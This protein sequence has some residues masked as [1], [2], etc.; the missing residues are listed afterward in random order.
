MK[1][2]PLR[3]HVGQYFDLLD[4]HYIIIPRVLRCGNSFKIDVA[5][6][7]IDSTH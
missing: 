7:E 5:N 3:F 1:C 6:Q 2:Y 4:Y